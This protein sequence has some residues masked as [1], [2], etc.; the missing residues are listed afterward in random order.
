VCDPPR[1]TLTCG[2]T[3]PLGEDVIA[4]NVHSW[5]EVADGALGMS[6]EEAAQ[7]E[8]S[9]DKRPDQLEARI[10][11]V[12]HYLARFSAPTQERRHI[13]LYWLIDNHP[14]VGLDGYGLIH[15]Q[16]HPREYSEGKRRWLEAVARRPTE[17][18]ILRH[19]SEY[20]MFADRDL[21]RDLVVRGLAIDGAGHWH[22]T[23]GLL[24]LQ[25]A[26]DERSEIKKRE[27]FKESVIEYER[28]LA[29]ESSCESL[30]GLA[31]A[32]LG[33]ADHAGAADAARAVL[34]QGVEV[35]SR[36]NGVHYANVV[37]GNIALVS[38]AVA[39]ALGH[40]AAARTIHHPFSVG[41][42][43]PDL[44]LAV[45][46]MALGQRDAVSEFLAACKPFC[47]AHQLDELI[48]R[49]DNGVDPIDPG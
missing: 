16:L 9:L 40:L 33:A 43:G 28:A 34:A 15:P 2:T 48:R 26:F 23:L 42:F 35:L 37:L 31:R 14:E 47:D 19:A 49:F 46:L 36:C 22:G 27:L 24:S 13:H 20:M 11:L 17:T 4:R 12:V 38:G 41:L 8:L 6:P 29:T 3:F 18:M 25:E 5:R 21:S 30:V 1:A 10:R 32:R 45:A 39:V 44:T 7:L